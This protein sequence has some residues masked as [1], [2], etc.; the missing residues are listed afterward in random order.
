M[1]IGRQSTHSD[2]R[3]AYA[4]GLDR[5]V[6]EP[7]WLYERDVARAWWSLPLHS[8]IPLSRG[9]AC[10]I[11]FAG[12]P[13]GSAGPD[14]R[15]A[16]L[17]FW[18]LPSSTEEGRLETRSGDVEFHIYASDWYTHQHHT[19]RRYNDV[20]LHVVLICDDA[21]PTWRQDGIVVPVCSL[22][23]VGLET[24]RPVL[25]NLLQGHIWPCQRNL[26]GDDEQERDVRLL[27]AGLLRFEEKRDHFLEELHTISQIQSIDD[28]YDSC[29]LPAL[30]EGLA[31]GRDR[32]LF[33]ALG[34]QLLARTG[35][36]PEPLGR[37]PAPSPLDAIRLG[38]LARLYRCWRVPGIWRTLRPLLLCQDDVCDPATILTTLRAHFGTLG[39]SQARTDILLCNI[40]YPFA[41]AV[42][43]LE[44]NSVLLERAQKLY[45]HH[46][47]LSSNRITRMMSSQLQ[48][49]NQPCG[50]CR[51]QGLHHIYRQ[52]CREK[53]CDLCI[54]AKDI[55]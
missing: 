22:G 53:R 17:R 29:L 32:I 34:K 5:Y 9:G 37:N 13:G 43:L 31:Y 19:D 24:S 42:A 14:V 54:M 23:D 48:L 41:A 15:D 49:S 28:G 35:T 12:H 55:L 27:R 44:Q 47:G 20:L 11:I 36:I 50:S 16:V 46:P 52:T 10:Q 26:A 45:L 38:V 7:D 6:R 1:M 4:S 40:V 39:L 3:S 18:L 21:H 2:Y 25:S 8:Y 30:A 33:R 51:Q